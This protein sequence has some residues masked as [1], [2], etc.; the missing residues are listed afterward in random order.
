[1][2]NR[3]YMDLAERIS[4]EGSCVFG[5]M[6]AV[7]GTNELT[8]L[9]CTALHCQPGCTRETG[10]CTLESGV[11]RL[12]AEVAANTGKLGKKE[13]MDLYLY[14]ADSSG[15]P[16][17]VTLDDSCWVMLQLAGLSVVYGCEDESHKLV[18]YD[19]YDSNRH[20]NPYWAQVKP[21]DMM[22]DSAKAA[23]VAKVE[24]SDALG[25]LWPVLLKLPEK[26]DTSTDSYKLMVE[27]RNFLQTADGQGYE[28]ST[29]EREELGLL[30]RLCFLECVP[31]VIIKNA[32]KEFPGLYANDKMERV[33]NQYR[34]SCVCG[35][36]DKGETITIFYFAKNNKISCE[37]ISHRDRL[38]RDLQHCFY[39]LSN[40][41]KGSPRYDIIR[42]LLDHDGKPSFT[43]KECTDKYSLAALDEICLD[44]EYRYELNG[45]PGQVNIRTLESLL[46]PNYMLEKQ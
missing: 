9:Y 2:A 19:F 45:K 24:D 29:L 8:P 6:A 18:R 27:R 44:Y 22:C 34:L 1:M 43:I 5:A 20:G 46:L 31:Y 38:R 40:S 28:M 30:E 7:V 3:Y 15:K 14:V 36:N 21:E 39:R 13:N 10:E 16:R 26:T 35:P 25:T 11:F 4:K 17:M 33:L 37:W 12:L 23:K 42:Q 32:E 41:E